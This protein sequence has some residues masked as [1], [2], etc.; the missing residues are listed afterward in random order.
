[1]KDVVGQVHCLVGD[2]LPEHF[3]VKMELNIEILQVI[4]FRLQDFSLKHFEILRV[5]QRRVVISEH[6]EYDHNNE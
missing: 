2:V 5:D 3:E 1:M 6:Y 4:F